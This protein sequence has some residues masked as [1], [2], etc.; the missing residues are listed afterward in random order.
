M[1]GFL[2]SHINKCQGGLAGTDSGRSFRLV[3]VGL[4]SYFPGFTLPP[5][6]SVRSD[7]GHPPAAPTPYHGQLSS[8]DVYDS[9]RSDLQDSDPLICN[10]RNCGAHFCAGRELF[11]SSV[12]MA[13]GEETP[14]MVS[15]SAVWLVVVG[16]L[17]VHRCRCRASLPQEWCSQ[18]V[19]R[20]K[21]LDQWVS[22]VRE[23]RDQVPMRVPGSERGSLDRERERESIHA[24]M[25]THTD[26]RRG[27]TESPEP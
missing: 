22:C 10:R 12:S 24:H 4:R 2:A 5:H 9:S 19:T 21:E 20:A 8:A 23:K 7:V 13:V 6:R 25:H 18:S 26:S 3:C 15:S 27:T 14:Q 16:T 17:S 1:Y 11:A